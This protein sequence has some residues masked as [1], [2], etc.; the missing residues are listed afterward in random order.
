MC[1]SSIFSLTG[2]PIKNDSRYSSLEAMM[3]LYIG[4]DNRLTDINVNTTFYASNIT[5]VY[6]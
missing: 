5:T 3:R 6:N 2:L 4:V 1:R